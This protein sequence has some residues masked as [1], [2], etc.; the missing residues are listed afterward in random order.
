MRG[1]AAS[2]PLAQHYF[3]CLVDR[4]NLEDTLCQIKTNCC[5]IAHGWLPLLVIF[6]DHHLGTSM[7]SG[8]I[9]PIS[10][11]V[12]LTRSRQRRLGS[13]IVQRTDFRPSLV[14]DPLGLVH[15]ADGLTLSS[16]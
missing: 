10:W 14:I 6:D 4:M 1:L 2:Q 5:N 16:Y 8:A 9:H 3:A 7:P 15:L 11:R 12:L 13:T